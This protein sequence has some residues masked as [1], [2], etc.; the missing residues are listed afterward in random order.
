M[1]V[2][3][4]KHLVQGT[5]YC[6]VLARL[7][8][9]GQDGQRGIVI[10]QKINLSVFAVVIVEELV[11]MRFQ[12]LCHDILIDSSKVDALLVLQYRAQVVAI[13]LGSRV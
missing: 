12:L 6:V 11:T 8:L 2:G 10:H 9:D 1:I 3:H 4:S 7:H 13:E 5:V